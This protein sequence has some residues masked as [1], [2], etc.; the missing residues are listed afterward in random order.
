M[1]IADLMLIDI[2]FANNSPNSPKPSIS[3][4]T[5]GISKH[6]LMPITP[7]TTLKNYNTQKYRFLVLVLLKYSL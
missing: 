2:A 6:R 5:D 7:T 3:G 1:N 4:D